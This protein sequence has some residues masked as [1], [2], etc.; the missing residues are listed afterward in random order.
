MEAFRAKGIEVLL[1]TDPV[2]ELWVDAV[3]GF[4]GKQLRS[5]A[6]G[7]I[8]LDGEEQT[9]EAESERE[10]RQ[11]EFAGL[12]GWM[13]EQ[14]GEEV[15]EVRLS[16]RL[17]VSPACVVSDTFD[18]TPAL[19]AMYKAMG[20]ELPNA[21]R[22]LELNPG[23]PLVTGLNRAH[24]ERADDPGLPETAELLYGMALLAEGG[25]PSDPARFIKLMA[26][27]VARTV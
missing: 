8:D 4:D 25:Q 2:D 15:K 10:K 6:K 24:A 7:E 3:P 1:L 12:L 13:T 14:L 27:R 11:Q 20:Q 19:Q 18:A 22:I 9:P 17:T 16:S 26:D 23:H 21:K 5:I